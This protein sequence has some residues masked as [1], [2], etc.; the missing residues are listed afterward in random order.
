MTEAVTKPN[1][2]V[3]IIQRVQR[4]ILTL[5]DTA[6]ILTPMARTKIDN[7]AVGKIPVLRVA[8]ISGDPKDQ[9]VY[10]LRQPKGRFALTK[11]G[12]MR[13]EAIAGIT[14]WTTVVEHANKSNEPGNFVADP[15]HVKARSRAQIQDIDGTIR[16]SE[17]LFELNLNDGSPQ[18]EKRVKIEDNGTRNEKELKQARVNIVQLAESMAQN[19]VRRNLLNLQST[20]TAQDLRKPFVIMRLVDAPLDASDPLIKKLIIMKQLNIS[21]EMYESAAQDLATQKTLPEP[22]N[23]SPQPGYD[24]PNNENKMEQE[25]RT[26]LVAEVFNLYQRKVKGGRDPKKVPLPALNT[27]ELN[28]IKDMLE[29]LPDLK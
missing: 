29:K 2:I 5:K 20:F 10:E 1:P 27:N 15:L 3:D 7:I 11:V 22:I 23:I 24:L 12:L 16:V 17:Q 9:E 25:E 6:H 8:A 14:G 19:R 4:E 18:A 21:S 28:Q 13:L 26:A